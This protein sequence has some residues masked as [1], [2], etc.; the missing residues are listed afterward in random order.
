MSWEGQLCP[1]P[2]TAPIGPASRGLAGTSCPGYPT[3]RRLHLDK[4]AASS[5]P[6]HQA[7][8]RELSLSRLRGVGWAPVGLSLHGELRHCLGQL[9][10]GGLHP[11]W[12]R[13][14]RSALC[15][16]HSLRSRG[17]RATCGDRACFTHLGPGG[18]GATGCG[19]AQG[20]LLGPAQPLPASHLPIPSTPTPWR[21]KRSSL[22]CRAS[23]GQERERRAG[24]SGSW[25]RGVLPSPITGTDLIYLFW[26]KKE[27]KQVCIAFGLTHKE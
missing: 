2:P 14:G 1:L 10:G 4:V 9:A 21:R 11:A 18:T 3:R 26:L 15:S 8:Q 23:A 17:S 5:H 24:P 12:H 25:R 22:C 16:V 13:E 20:S 19:G 27:Q 7:P 6:E